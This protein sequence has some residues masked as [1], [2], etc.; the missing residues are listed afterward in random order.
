[1]FGLLNVSEKTKKLKNLQFMSG[2]IKTQLFFHRKSTRI[3][4]LSASWFMNFM[5]FA[6][7]SCDASYTSTPGKLQLTYIRRLMFVS[8]AFD[9]SHDYLNVWKVQ[10][11]FESVY[12]EENHTI[13]AG[14][15][16]ALMKVKLHLDYDK[17][18]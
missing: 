16:T 5:D 11:V 12:F 3:S 15:I 2:S 18:F 9:F 14:V 4:S 1:M 13:S 17:L 6:F 8:H 7:L 10:T